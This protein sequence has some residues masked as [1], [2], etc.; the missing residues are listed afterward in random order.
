[1]VPE[2]T[3]PGKISQ[4]CQIRDLRAVQVGLA[5]LQGASLLAMDICQNIE[6]SLQQLHQLVLELQS[7]ERLR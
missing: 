4:R 1:M 6:T 3:Q 7:Q 5:Q 2:Y